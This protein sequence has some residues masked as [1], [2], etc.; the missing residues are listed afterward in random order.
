VFSFI[1]SSAFGIG[2]SLCGH[3]LVYSILDADHWYLILIL[4]F[5]LPL[6]STLGDFVFSS[7][8]RYF[9][10][11]DFGNIIPGHG[12]M[13]DRLDSAIFTMITTAAF[14]STVIYWTGMK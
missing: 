10:I 13:L 4:S 1:A 2:F 5:I 3:P 6:V 12:G 8:K 14:L 9:G 7:C 11:K